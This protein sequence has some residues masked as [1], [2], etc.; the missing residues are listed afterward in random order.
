MDK[1]YN[2]NVPALTSQLT[3]LSLL[4]QKDHID[5]SPKEV[6]RKNTGQHGTGTVQIDPLGPLVKI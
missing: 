5:V 1:K 4:L 2:N 3:L 6:E